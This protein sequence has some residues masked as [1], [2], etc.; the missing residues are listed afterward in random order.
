[1][2]PNPCHVIS[3]VRL[4]CKPLVR[5]YSKIKKIF[6][7]GKIFT[8]VSISHHSHKT[9]IHC[10]LKVALLCIY[11][12]S[13]FCTVMHRPDTGVRMASPMLGLQRW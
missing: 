5:H 11:Y 8:F 1:M 10:L 3:K 7:N 2:I 6:G 9:L 12:A 4:D 13:L